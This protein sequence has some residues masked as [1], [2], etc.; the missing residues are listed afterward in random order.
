MQDNPQA[1]EDIIRVAEHLDM[2]VAFG[3]QVP[4]EVMA[5]SQ[6]LMRLYS[7]KLATE[8]TECRLDGR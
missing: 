6:R 2:L 7:R 4:A 8:R 5:A 1:R 3:C